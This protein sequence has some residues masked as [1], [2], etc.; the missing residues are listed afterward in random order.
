MASSILIAED[1]ATSRNLLNRVL[2]QEGYAVI[3]SIDGEDALQKLNR[4]TSLAIIDLRMPKMGGIACIQQIKGQYPDIPVIVISSA[5]TRDAVN[6]MQNGA[7]SYIQKPYRR[8]EVLTVVENAIAHRKKIVE[9][10]QRTSAL[11]HIAQDERGQLHELDRQATDALHTLAADGKPVLVYGE[12]GTPIESFAQLVHAHLLHGERPMTRCNLNGLPLERLR[13]ELFGTADFQISTPGEIPAFSGR[14]GMA[15]GGS[16][17]LGELSKAPYPLQRDLITL[18]QQPLDLQW[19]VTTRYDFRLLIEQG[20]LDS[21]FAELFGERLIPLTA[22]RKRR[23]TI[24]EEVQLLLQHFIAK[25]SPTPVEIEDE[26]LNRLIEY[27][28]PGNSE[29]LERVLER[30]LHEAA[31]E[32]I[33]ADHLFFEEVE[34]LERDQKLTELA[35]LPLR[36]IENFFISWQLRKHNGNRSATARSLGITDRTVYNRIKQFGIL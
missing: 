27:S 5:G 30:A 31:G 11:I 36:E 4:E 2:S 17:M 35:D 6:A 23:S 20:F 28:W 15:E 1:D 25:A 14:L 33:R 9:K 24:G 12:R 7:F 34:Q 19:I 3:S 10:H 29:Q 26:A 32:A 22:L 13:D 18:M 16:L 21:Q 8:E